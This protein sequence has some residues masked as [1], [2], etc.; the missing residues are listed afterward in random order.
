MTS[1]PILRHSKE[2]LILNSHYARPTKTLRR[3]KLPKKYS[4]PSNSKYGKKTQNILL[5]ND[6]SNWSS[7]VEDFFG[8]KHAY[9]A[10]TPQIL[11]RFFREIFL[12]KDLSCQ[13]LKIRIIAPN[14]WPMED[15]R[16][17]VGFS[18]GVG[19]MV[20][21]RVSVMRMLRICTA[22]WVIGQWNSKRYKCN[23]WSKSLK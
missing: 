23:T 17:V 11:P 15:E 21:I 4:P 16:S 7:F 3:D 18:F 14:W 10:R 2:S 19:V 12:W 5:F 22:L 20:K 9:Y 8:W 6:F 1:Q 13:K